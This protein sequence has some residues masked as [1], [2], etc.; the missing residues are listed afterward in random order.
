MA[1]I[2]LHTLGSAGDLNP[3][4]A[5]AFELRERGHSIRFAV[6]PASAARITALGLDAV[7]V[8]PD[9]APDSALMRKLLTP[10]IFGPI[11]TLFRDVLIPAI[12]PAAD[13][14]SPLC[15]DADIFISHIVQVAAPVIASRTGVRW[16]S[17]TPTTNCYPSKFG[18]APGIA[19]RNP[20][21]A[22]N[23]LAW[24]A[25]RALLKDLNALLDEQYTLLGAPPRDRGAL[26]GAFSE[27][28]TIGLWSPAFFKRPPDWPDWFQIGG[29]AR[30][31]APGGAPLG[32]LPAGNSPL[33]VFTLGSSVVNDPRGYYETA[34]EAVRQ[35]DW[36]AVL[37]GAPED[38]K[39]APDLKHRVVALRYAPY[40]ELFPQASAIVH[41]G[42]VGT[43]Q[44]ACYYGVPAIVVPRGF[45]QFEN[46]AHIQRHRLGLRLMPSSFSATLLRIRLERLLSDV[47]TVRK[48]QELSLKMQAE[49]GVARSADLVE[50][51]LD[52]D[53]TASVLSQSMIYGSEIGMPA[54]G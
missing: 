31:D 51:A 33:V 17:A 10:G 43:T 42:G 12:G 37:L 8:G 3:F 14:I 9:L 47:N 35:T 5:L 13:A 16:I 23:N 22:L 29:Y 48:V 49:A 52:S 38:F 30:W 11:D 21:S 45:D 18:D 54:S 34:M 1:R 25:A 39:V 15:E 20:P 6:S 44:A 32:T 40:A 19:W 24:T 41:Q 36:R 4:L 28:L 50:M 46:A 2:L 26:L 27:F 53:F 7:A